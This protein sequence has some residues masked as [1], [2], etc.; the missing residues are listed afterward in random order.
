MKYNIKPNTCGIYQIRNKINN[1]SYIGSSVNISSRCSNH[2]NR[3]ARKYYWRDFYKDVIYYGQCNFEF[4]VLE[5]CDKDKLIER[6]QY[7]YDLIKPEYNFSKPIENPFLLKEI[8]DLAH[9][10][11]RYYK[12]IE[13]RK[14]NY[15]TLYYKKLFSSIQNKRK[16]PVN[17]YKDGKLIN[18]FESMSEA[19]RYIELNTNFKGKNKVAKIKSVCDG[20]RKTAYGY[21]FE[22]KV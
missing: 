20:E 12:S 8:N 5:E 1:K 2:M 17:M 9:S 16:K 14:R 21:I 10:T 11:E 4:I 6:E 3:D 7:Y 19:A 13:R 22:Y 18:T 15:N